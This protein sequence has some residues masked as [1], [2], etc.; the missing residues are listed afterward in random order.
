VL[1]RLLLPLLA[2][3]AFVGC[4]ND[5][6]EVPAGPDGAPDAELVLG[7]EVYAARCASCHGESGGGGAGPSVRGERIVERYPDIADQ[8]AVVADG[9]NGMPAFEDVLS[10]EQ[11]EAVVRYT[12]E[13]L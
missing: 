10:P 3:A 13:V 6:P 5:P 8:I 1:R 12:R 7:R 9:R 4:A 11:I 2:A